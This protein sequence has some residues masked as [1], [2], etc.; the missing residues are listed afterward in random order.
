MS[1]QHYTYDEVLCFSE[2]S[3][4][5]STVRK[6]YYEWR[7]IQKKPLQCDN[8]SC[9]LHTKPLTWND[10]KLTLILDHINGNQKDNRHENLRLLCPNCDSQNDT[11][12]GKNKGRIQNQTATGYEIANRDGTRSANVFLEGVSAI[13]ILNSG[14]A[15]SSDDEG[16]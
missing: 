14:T 10:K 13:G 3:K 2:Q 12:G 9:Q 8:E 4:P 1:R 16:G 7:E 6:Y 15:C 5:R 11:R